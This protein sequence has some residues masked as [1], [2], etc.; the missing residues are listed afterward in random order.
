M[1]ARKDTATFK[2]LTWRE[3]AQRREARRAVKRSVQSGD[4]RKPMCCSSCGTPT[5][6]SELHG[7][8]D[9][10]GQPLDVRWLCKRCHHGEHDRGERDSAPAVR[11]SAPA[12]LTQRQQTI[13]AAIGEYEAFIGE[14]CPSTYL[15]RRFSLHHSTVQEHLSTLYRKGWLIAPNAPS[16][17]RK[18]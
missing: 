1:A 7:H 5:H 16:T 10:Y 3:S 4:I 12:P 2:P 18:R 13:L 8:H 15:A 6:K 9:D 14:P 11:V 17:L